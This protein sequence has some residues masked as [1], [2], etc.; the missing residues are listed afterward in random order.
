[1]SKIKKIRKRIQSVKNTQK[2]TRAMQMVAAVQMAKA[3]EEA[4]G[5]R[6]YA[7]RVTDTLG[8]AAGGDEA[9]SHP[10]L[11]PSEDEDL[12]VLLVVFAGEKGLCGGF[13]SAVFRKA[14]AVIKERCSDGEIRLAVWGKKAEDHYAKKQEFFPWPSG[15]RPSDLSEG[16]IW[17]GEQIRA[18]FLKGNFKRVELVYSV[19]VSAMTQKP[20]V[21]QLLPMDL[22]PPG[23]DSLVIL[24]PDRTTLV[25]NLLELYLETKIGQVLLETKAGELG[26]RMTAMENATRN[27]DE[28]IDHLTLQF[29]K[30]RQTA[31]TKDI[32]EVITGAEA[33]EAG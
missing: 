23:E 4:E 25:E 19:F 17:L 14:D 5:Q 2:I 13:N 21:E 29:N 15:Q 3:K 22:P 31:I 30:A 27:A 10:L 28:M 32:L 18:E 24:E 8:L 7:G 6:E 33:M 20:T 9:Y 1:M 26:A 12:P 11:T 16:T